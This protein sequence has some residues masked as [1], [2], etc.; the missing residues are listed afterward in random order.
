MFFSFTATQEKEPLLLL[1][2]KE[3]LPT[4]AATSRS[5]LRS[6]LMRW[7][8]TGGIRL[9]ATSCSPYSYRR[10]SRGRPRR[11]RGRG[12]SR[13]HPIRGEQA[14]LTQLEGKKWNT[15]FE[16]PRR[17]P[18]PDPNDPDVGHFCAPWVEGF[19]EANFC[20]FHHPVAGTVRPATAAAAATATGASTAP[21]A[22]PLHQ[23]PQQHH[24]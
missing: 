20:I 18:T 6:S 12:R 5:S 16:F 23:Q 17:P 9:R 14:L 10:R 13:G 24:N 2:R 15:K 3:A 7:R 19:C 1:K 21:S 11:G 8:W 22:P 4:A